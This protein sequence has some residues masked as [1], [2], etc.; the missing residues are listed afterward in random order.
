M[1]WHVGRLKAVSGIQRSISFK[2]LGLSI[3]IIVFGILFAALIPLLPL[4]IIVLVLGGIG[5]LLLLAL[6]IEKLLIATI[7]VA[8][9]VIGPVE[10]FGGFRVIWLVS[11]MAIL[12]MFKSILQWAGNH[13]R[14]VATAIPLPGFFVLLFL[15][16]AVQFVG[17]LAQPPSRGLLVLEVR[18]RLLPW[19]LLLPFLTGQIS[20]LAC[21]RI[22]KFIIAVGFIQLPLVLA[23]Y[24]LYARTRTDDTWW[25]AIVGTFIGNPKTGGD[26]G[27]MALFVITIAALLVAAWRTGALSGKRVIVLL[28]LLLSSLFLSEVKVALVLIPLA[29]IA[30][31]WKD[32]IRRPALGI[33]ALALTAVLMGGIYLAYGA[34]FGQTRSGTGGLESGIKF[35]FDPTVIKA[36][37][38]MGR[39][40]SL[41]YWWKHGGDT[42]GTPG[43]V[44]GNGIGASNSDNPYDLGPVAKRKYPLHIAATG[45]SLLLW[46]AGV[47]GTLAYIWAL[48]LV[49]LRS[50][51]LAEK[52]TDPRAQSLLLGFSAI[53]VMSVVHLFYTKSVAGHTPQTY[54]LLVVMVGTILVLD[55][56]RDRTNVSAI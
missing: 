39:Y 5:G 29:T 45:I 55:R 16:F 21:Q 49:A 40:A 32:F 50:Q 47:A 11:G 28:P 18:D 12:V 22:W 23:Q 52:V 10:Y 20:W 38:E 30:L 51:R 27:A 42:L 17:V 46:E 25:D 24:F 37:G 43:Y 36:N 54:I 31:F 19:V 56:S 3:A 34:V 15:F 8:F 13:R 2:G 41:D 1:T 6:D 35:A 7:A 44:L 14:A 26:S 33:G 53:L 4:K 48:A 9:L